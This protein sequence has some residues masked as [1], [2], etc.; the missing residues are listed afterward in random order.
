[1]ARLTLLA[2]SIQAAILA[3]P[4]GTGRDPITERQLRPIAAEPDWTTQ[5]KMWGRLP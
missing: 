2:P 4:P 5:I 3:L 1:V